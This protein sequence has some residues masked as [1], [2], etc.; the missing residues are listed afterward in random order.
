[1]RQTSSTL[2]LF[3]A[4]AVL[5]LAQ[6]TVAQN[7]QAA[8]ASLPEADA[9]IYVSP[10]RILNEAAPR[11]MKPADVTSMRATFADLKKAIGVDP[12]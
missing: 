5:A 11:V 7:P 3:A 1:M 8:L 4:V 9:L 2:L 6:H 10:Q 12:G